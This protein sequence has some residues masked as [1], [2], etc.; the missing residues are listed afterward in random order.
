MTRHTTLFE[1]AAD[2]TTDAVGT[3]RDATLDFL[4]NT[5]KPFVDDFV[6]DTAKPFIEDTAKPRLHDA[7]ART[8]PLV[9]AGASV[10]AQRAAQAKEYAEARSQELTGYPKKKRRGRKLLTF[11]LIGGLAAAAAVLA[12]RFLGDSGE[13]TS[14]TSTPSGSTTSS[15]SSSTGAA[16][17]QTPGETFATDEPADDLTTPINKPPYSSN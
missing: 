17:P 10:A 11:A 2:K 12:R 9:A 16:R 5:A 15:S 14:S 13:W 3:A 1:R 7:A 4:E 6:E 8:A